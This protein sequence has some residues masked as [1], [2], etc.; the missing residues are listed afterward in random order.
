ME[1]KGLF[2][3]VATIGLLAGVLGAQE[4]PILENVGKPIQLPFHCT[5]ED[6]QWGGLSCT[7]EEP[8]PIYLELTGVESI[9]NKLFTTGNLHAQTITLY[10]VLLGSD[11]AGSTWREAYQRIRGAGLDRIQFSDFENGWASGEALSPLPQDPFLLITTDG[12]KTW[13]QHAIFSEPR[14][15][16]I[17]QIVFPSKKQGDLVFDRGAGTGEERYEHYESSDGGETWNI[18]EA[19]NQPIRLKEAATPSSVWRIQADGKTQAFR[20]EHQT[21]G[22]WAAASA[23]AIN[24]GTCA[25]NNQ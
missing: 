17:Q 13:H 15:G 4:A 12:G 2:R 3:K 10:S 9:G 5:D 21:G 24:L 6:I 25:P 8:C 14:V 7:A 19:T 1:N 16:S 23:F 18:Q 20:I 11:D 22:R